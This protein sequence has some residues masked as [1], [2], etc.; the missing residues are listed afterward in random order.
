MREGDMFAAV[1]SGGRLSSPEADEVHRLFAEWRR[2]SSERLNQ[3]RLSYS[4]ERALDAFA[5]TLLAAL[6]E[7]SDGNHLGARD[8]YLRLL[9]RVPHSHEMQ[10]RLRRALVHVLIRLGDTERSERLIRKTISRVSFDALDLQVQ[11]AL[12]S[13]LGRV[14]RKKGWLS[15]ASKVYRETFSLMVPRSREWF[16]VLGSRFHAELRADRLDIARE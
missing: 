13:D 4:G 14:Y 3:E 11:L 16:M 15:L 9:R 12:R 10:F 1:K 7:M 6:A 5:R 8:L 2:W